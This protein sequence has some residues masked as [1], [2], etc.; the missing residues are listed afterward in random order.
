MMTATIQT[1]LLLLAVGVVVAVVA[2]RLNTAPSILLVI[3]GVALALIP[4]LPSI[5]LAP[6][7]VLLV[8]LPFEAIAV[9]LF[10]MLADY[11]NTYPVQFL[12]FI[13]NAFSIYLFYTFFV[14]LPKQIE[15]AARVGG[16]GLKHLTGLK[17]L[18]AMRLWNVPLTDADLESLQSL[19]SLEELSL[20]G[21]RGVTDRGL[22]HLQVLTGLKEL[23][24]RE[25]GVTREGAEALRKVL[26]RT[27]VLR[28]N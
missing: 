10:Y 27:Q 18:R 11:R 28:R 14:G 5:E 12:P 19:T 24:L 22:E 23:D 4:G 3:A 16:A 1:L 8:I 6:E 26:L 13:A 25:T 17:N 7:F 20:K 15:E 21:A 9:P 2:Q